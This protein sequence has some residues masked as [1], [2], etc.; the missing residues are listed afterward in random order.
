ML[1]HRQKCFTSCWAKIFHPHSSR[2]TL[3]NAICS[4]NEANACKVHGR[5]GRKAKH[6]ISS[7]APVSQHLGHPL[8]HS[9]NAKNEVNFP[10]KGEKAK[11]S[12]R[13]EKKPRQTVCDCHISGVKKPMVTETEQKLRLLP[14]SV[15][16][17]QNKSTSPVF[18]LF[19]L[20]NTSS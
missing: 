4:T 17:S 18:R 9:D 12:T 8:N 16:K 14:D 11:F 19:G 6:R 3:W 15:F 1:G 2:R 13:A 10:K 20:K 5:K 7:L